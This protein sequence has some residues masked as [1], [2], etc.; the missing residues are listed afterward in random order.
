MSFGLAGILIL[1]I[2]IGLSMAA[3]PTGLQEV[4]PALLQFFDAYLIPFMLGIAFLVFVWNAIKFFVVK[5]STEEGRENA[6][7]LAI[8]SI[9]A[10]VFI[11]SF[12]GIINIF[13]NGLGLDNCNNDVVPDYL[14][15]EYTSYAPCTSPRPQPRPGNLNNGGGGAPPANVLPVNGPQ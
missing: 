3:S 10:F 4:L 6:K 12:W 7:S 9:A 1:V 5:G 2:V 11:L 8:Y 15:D 13:T 14:S